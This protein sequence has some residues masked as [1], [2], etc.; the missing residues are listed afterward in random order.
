MIV[1]LYAWSINDDIRSLNKLRKSL[2]VLF[3]HYVIF[4]VGYCQ[5]PDPTIFLMCLLS[6]LGGEDRNRGST[7]TQQLTR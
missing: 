1:P 7:S 4:C 5:S 2:R 3:C 6:V